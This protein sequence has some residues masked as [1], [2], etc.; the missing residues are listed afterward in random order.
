MGAFDVAAINSRRAQLRS[1][2]RLRVAVGAALLGVAI[3][4]PAEADDRALEQVT[5]ESSTIVVQFSCPM[6]YVS[7]YPLRTGDEL[8]IELQ[9][10][11]G[12]RPQSGIGETLPVPA[13]NSAGLVELRIDQSLGSRRS[14]TLHFSR[15]V[16]FLIRP[17]SGLTGIEIALTMRAGRVKVESAEAPPRPSRNSTRELPPKEELDEILANARTAMQDRD[18]DTAIRLYTKLLEYPE[19]AARSQAQEYVGLAH[20]RKGDMA[21]AKAEYEE[22]LRRYP[23]GSDI[24]SVRQRLAAIVTLDG[25]SRPSRG[26]VDSSPWSITG[27]IAQDIRHDNNTV[28]ANGIT[29][30]GVGQ[31]AIDS[32]ADVQVKHR[33]EIYDFKARMF[34]GYIHDMLSGTGATANQVRL[35][36][37]FVELDNKASN[38]LGRVGR[39]SQSTGGSYGNFDGGYFSWQMRPGLRLGVAAGS[40]VQTYDASV[41]HDR[42][43]GNVS[44]EA[45]GVLPGLDVTGYVFNQQTAG[46]LDSRQLGLETRYYR[47]GRSVSTQLD[48]DLS[49]KELNSVTLLGSWSL[50]SRWVL[51][52]LLDHRHAPFYS[53]YSALIGQ[54]TTDIKELISTLGIDQVRQLARDRSALSDM[55]TFG[56][57]RPIGEQIQWGADLYMSRV[58]GTP[59]SGGVAATPATGTAVGFSTQ[60]TGGG[61]LV[62]GDVDTVGV[63]Y[64]TRQGTRSISTYF[65]SRYPVGPSLRIGPRLQVSHNS[66]SDPATGTSSGWSLSPSLLADWRLK[67][68]SVQF[69][70]GYEHATLDSSFAQGV[71]IDPTLPPTT[72]QRTSRYWVGL[73]Y[74]LSF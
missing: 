43:F 67:H 53:V 70:A 61:W 19:H 54:P 62:D 60:L 57:Q 1:S 18:Y 25:A 33:G 65:S 22:Y 29:S 37:A 42:T 56:V 13:D 58:G 55:V 12:C 48:Y 15:T 7:N 28:T 10:L 27:G 8:R 9:P 14:L 74:N 39:Q 5:I 47:N 24:E 71:P 66:G 21:L 6:S 2:A 72:D 23:D 17:R 11:P 4:T 31:S 16:D 63:S 32:E 38:W 45:M 46:V 59:A 52:A 20:E 64:T 44:L 30:N 36:Q 50:E 49:F 41:S 3:A 73:G 68:G 34:A 35:P 40:P 26:A 51:T 69:Q